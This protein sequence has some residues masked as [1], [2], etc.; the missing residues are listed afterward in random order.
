MIEQG[1]NDIGAF[2]NKFQ[3]IFSN[4]FLFLDRKKIETALGVYKPTKTN[5]LATVEQK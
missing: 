2:V 1:K 5:Q 4:S 3:L